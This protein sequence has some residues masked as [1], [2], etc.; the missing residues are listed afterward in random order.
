MDALLALPVAGNHTI[1]WMDWEI[2][3]LGDR[4][5]GGLVRAIEILRNAPVVSGGRRRIAT[6][7]Q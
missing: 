5:A 1:D 6:I 7:I 4:K 3:R 2:E